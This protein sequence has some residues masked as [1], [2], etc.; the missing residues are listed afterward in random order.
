MVQPV[1]PTDIPDRAI[2]IILFH[3]EEIPLYSVRSIF[4]LTDRPFMVTD[5]IIIVSTPSGN[6]AL[7]VDKTSILH[8]F[9]TTHYQ[10]YSHGEVLPHIPGT[11]QSPQGFLVFSEISKVL[12]FIRSQPHSSAIK[13]AA[14]VQQISQI[15]SS[16]TKVLPTDSKT[17]LQKRAS[18]LAH[19][20]EVH[21]LVPLRKVLT[22]S[23][24][25]QKFAL[26]TTYIR[27][28]IT[29]HEIVPV[30]NTPDFVVGICSVRGEII[31]LVDFLILIQEK[32][33]ALTNCNQV[34]VLTNQKITFGILVD[35]ILGIDTIREDA[36]TTASLSSFQMKSKFIHGVAEDS[37][38]ILDGEAILSDPDL[39]IDHTDHLTDTYGT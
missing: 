27:E 12:E 34:I 8:N 26:E 2:G 3:G 33:T 14:D 18:E 6:I 11:H 13:S 36:I 31:S 21:T 19:P 20:E 35:L 23:R 39:I 5:N 28:V 29:V 10:L 9:D 30:P 38:I 1:V 17:I 32:N 7:W 16:D 24:A 22:F 37:L 15:F 25:Y 4:G